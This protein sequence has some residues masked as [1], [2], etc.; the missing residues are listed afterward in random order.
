MSAQQP[1][2]LIARDRPT[3]GWQPAVHASLNVLPRPTRYRTRRDQTLAEA[4]TTSARLNRQIP[5]TGLS[6]SLVIGT[7]PSNHVTTQCSHPPRFL[8][9]FAPVS[10]RSSTNH[11]PRKRPIVRSD[12]IK[13]GKM[14]ISNTGLV[15]IQG[16]GI[17][18]QT[19]PESS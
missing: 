10:L 18:T 9:Q 17:R 12:R 15:R 8:R 5:A 3:T 1:R 2:E 6:P 11:P 16:T 13:N 19:K 14:P 7:F 4:S